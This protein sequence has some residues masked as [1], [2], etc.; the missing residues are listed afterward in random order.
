MFLES[1]NTCYGDGGTGTAAYHPPGLIEMSEAAAVRAIVRGEAHLDMLED[2]SIR[3]SAARIT[4]SGRRFGAA[5]L[6]LTAA[7]L[8]QGILSQMHNPAALAEW[9]SFILVAGELFIFADRK[10]EACDRLLA[11]VWSV[12][13]GGHISQS[14]IRLAQSLRGQSAAA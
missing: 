2:T 3:I 5:F 13:F 4:K 11:S 8:A 9:A 7:D 12:A 10:T 6:V 14:A 1:V